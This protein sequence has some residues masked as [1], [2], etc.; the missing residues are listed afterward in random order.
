MGGNILFEGIFCSRAILLRVY[1]VVERQKQGPF[2]RV[3][4]KGRSKPV[5]HLALKAQGGVDVGELASD[6]CHG[7]GVVVVMELLRPSLVG[8]D[9]QNLRSKSRENFHWSAPFTQGLA[10][11]NAAAVKSRLECIEVGVAMG[12][13]SLLLQGTQAHGT[14]LDPRLQP[15]LQHRVQ[16]WC[17]HLDQANLFLLSL[18]VSKLS[19]V[20]LWIL[21]PDLNMFLKME[22]FTMGIENFRMGIVN[23]CCW[24]VLSQPFNSSFSLLGQ[25]LQRLMIE[26]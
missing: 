4:L 5:V 22:N 26:Q 3:G 11:H 23:T 9:I 6:R 25:E 2:A 14:L 10:E 19:L 20:C 18:L 15:L 13:H 7:K 1:F 24:G 12:A 8:E 21:V 17:K 16:H